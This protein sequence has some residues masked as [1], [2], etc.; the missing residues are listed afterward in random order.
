MHAACILVLTERLNI[1]GGKMRCGWA[2][3][4]YI[5]GLVETM[6][7]YTCMS[8]YI[9]TIA[10]HVGHIWLERGKKEQRVIGKHTDREKEREKE[11]ER[12]RKRERKREKA[13]KGEKKRV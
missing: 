2:R 8:P 7:R 6:S 13:R 12:E 9:I 10:G 1:L 5:R 3:K 4:S 11:R